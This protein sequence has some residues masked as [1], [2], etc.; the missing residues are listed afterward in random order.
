MGRLP[1]TWAGRKITMRVPY[2]MAGEVTLVSLQAGLQFPDATFQHNVD[3]PFEVHRA[4]PFIIAL[5]ANSLPVNPQPTQ[6]TLQA[7]LRVRISDLG[8]NEL[9]TKTP[10]LIGLIVK[11]TAEA[12]WEWA[13]PYTIVRSE[14]FQVVVD[15]LS[16]ANFAGDGITKLVLGWAFQ[17]FLLVV[18][19]PSESR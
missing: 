10:T 13:E 9:I 18:A 5:D 3:K 15:A 16:L 6:E 7:L 14:S 4:K 2:E 11:G 17:G 1:D 19:P 12:T 8:K